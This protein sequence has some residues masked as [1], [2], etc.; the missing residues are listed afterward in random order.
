VGATPPTLQA[1]GNLAINT[2]GDLTVVLPAH[3][4][5]D[6]LVVV[7]G[8]WA[9]NTSSNINAFTTPSGGWTQGSTVNI[10]PGAQTDGRFGVY[11]LRASGGSTT[12]P[13]FTRGGNWDTGT[14]TAFFGR[15]FVIRGCIPTGTPFD[16]LDPTAAYT[17]DDQSFDA[18]TV[19]AG[20]RLAVQFG[21]KTG[22]NAWGTVAGWTAGTAAGSSTGT[23]A[24]TRP[25]TK[26]TSSNTNGTDAPSTNTAPAAGAYCFFGF[27]FI[28]D[29]IRVSLTPATETDV[30]VA[31]CKKFRPNTGDRY[32]NAV[33]ALT[34]ALYWRMDE[35]LGWP[36]IT[37]AS[38]NNR[39]G[40]G[41]A[42]TDEPGNA[43]VG[44]WESNAATNGMGK[45]GR[46][47]NPF[48]IEQWVEA[49]SYAPY[50]SPGSRTYC[51]WAKRTDDTSFRIILGGSGFEKGDNKNPTLE[52]I[53]PDGAMLY[54]SDIST[55][56]PCSTA[57]WDAEVPMNAWFFWALTVSDPGAGAV[58]QT[59]ELFIG[60][61]D[62]SFGSVG[63]A[64]PSGSQV[65]SNCEVGDSFAGTNGT[66]LSAHTENGYTWTNQAGAVLL[67][68]AGMCYVS[69]AP[70]AYYASA[71]H[72]GGADHRVTG[73]W[74]QA[75]AGSGRIGV[76]GRW[77]TSQRSGYALLHDASNGRWSLS[78]FDNGTETVL[79]TY[80]EDI[81]GDGDVQAV[82]AMKG[83]RIRA[84]IRGY[85]RIDKTDSTY[86]SDG[87]SG[88]VGT[89]AAS[90]VKLTAILFG[91]PF[92]YNAKPH[93][94]LSGKLRLGIHGNFNPS[95]WWKG[96]MDEVAVFHSVLSSSQIAGLFA[97]RAVTLTPASETDTA[98]ALGH[99]RVVKLTPA[100]EADTGQPLHASKQL[101][102]TPAAESDS[103][104]AL[105]GAKAV[106]LDPADEADLAEPL[107]GAK[108]V[109]LTPALELDEALTGVA[110][111]MVTLSPA[112]EFDE[113]LTM[114]ARV[115][116]Q[117]ALETD[118]ALG[119]RGSKLLTLVP[120]E[121]V[122][123]A[124]DLVASTLVTL[125]VATEDDVAQVLT[126]TRL[127][128]LGVA[129]EVDLAVALTYF[130]IYR[131]TPALEID[132]ALGAVPIPR[133]LVSRLAA[134]GPKVMG[135][136]SPVRPA[137]R[138]VKRLG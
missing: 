29:K 53:S 10:V 79:G 42:S 133:R 90:A 1:Q 89:V 126:F 75:G 16:E 70:T 130:R 74:N 83:N 119:L 58:N 107:S 78:R 26:E 11:W 68:G 69:T 106:T 48:G 7:I 14:D 127:Y 47:F 66:N 104:V 40:A 4:A 15:A 46:D 124:V 35:T 52:V 115:R 55:E 64:E 81:I 56:F 93:N 34:P 57:F 67:D 94:P 45:K 108:A 113:A 87:K 9:P 39:H 62:G 132:T 131:L 117:P 72:P 21:V 30:G 6:I 122:D 121:E 101:G 24:Q 109:T 71:T 38:G 18:L 96:S 128:H 85:L 23:G 111:K 65:F 63:K 136:D 105:A 76:T 110:Q 59:C 123:V 114:I 54:Y 97:A 8:I 91:N 135:G 25:F 19:S 120:A 37:D 103:G 116:L 84:I 137:V 44:G 51:G 60:R 92:G 3:Q 88:V 36:G 73:S 138:G 95:E 20:N 61:M 50:A 43:V 129:L 125:G 13:T 86:A 5:D 12:D 98:Q 33:M 31:L 118:T 112:L 41:H 32:Y 2:T 100:T 99:H 28:P 80:D 49:I 82:L 22:N 134:A 27:S 102:V 17:T 77:S